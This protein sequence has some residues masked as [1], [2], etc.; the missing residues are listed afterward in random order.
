MTKPQNPKPAG[1]SSQLVI[2]PVLFALYPTLFLYGNNAHLYDASVVLVP[3]AASLAV[4]L[5]LWWILNR[6]LKNP[7]ASGVLVSLLFLIGS[8]FGPILD[9]VARAELAKQGFADSGMGTGDAIILACVAAGVAAVVLL[10]KF[11][12]LSYQM[13]YAMN[14]IGTVLIAVPF[15][16]AG[17]ALVVTYLAADLLPA[18]RAAVRPLSVPGDAPDIYHIVLDGYGREDVFEEIYGYDNSYFVDFLESRGFYV[19][20]EAVSN[21]SQTVTSLSSALNMDYLDDLVGDG[22]AGLTDRRFLR[23]LARDSRAVRILH[24]SGYRTYAYESSHYEIQIGDPDVPL[25]PSGAMHPFH[26]AVLDMTPIPWLMGRFGHPLLYDRHREM[27]Q[28]P[29]ETL[30]EIARE[31]G[32]KFVY[33]HLLAAHP[34][35]VFEKDGAPYN[36][37]RRFSL[38][39][40]GEMEEHMVGYR[41]QV[42]YMNHRLM[43]TID[44]ILANSARTPVI[45][46]HGDHGPGSRLNPGAIENSD[47]HERLSILNAY[48]LPGRDAE[49]AL[50]PGISP[51]N[52]YRVVFNEYLGGDFELLEDRCYVSEFLTPYR[53][54]A[55]ETPGRSGEH[56]S[57][58]ASSASAGDVIRSQP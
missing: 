29:L 6:I 27:M 48:L 36:P 25:R 15:V 19:A 10:V 9:Q 46:L 28:F 57:S 30:P 34:P 47:L 51:V 40:M 11:P 12:S 33:A 18:E 26:L 49:T 53:F 39:I 31:P 21:Y 38:M 2:H 5:A 14:V 54:I 8:S 35:F 43:E 7:R 41:N 37:N 13:T 55:V 52:S 1:A 17:R 22:L 24:D 16:N 56:V 58:R 50:R 42:E 3:A 20:P 4:G 23:D 45:I 32:P 44:G